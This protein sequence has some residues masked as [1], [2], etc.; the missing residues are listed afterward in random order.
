MPHLKPFFE[1]IGIFLLNLSTRLVYFYIVGVRDGGD[2][3]FYVQN[4]RTVLENFGNPFAL[5]DQ[6]IYPYYWLYPFFLIAFQIQA[7]A[8]IITQVILQSL[9]AVL[10]YQIGKKLWSAPVGLIAGVAYA[11]F[12][13]VFQWDLYMLTDSLY[14]SMMI[15]SVYLVMGAV[16]R[17]TAAAWLA[18]TFSMVGLFLLRPTSV[19]YLASVGFLGAMPMP[20]KFRLYVALVALTAIV[21]GGGY[22]TAYGSQKAFGVAYSV[23]YYKDLLR[24]GVVVRDRPEYSLSLTWDSSFTI[25]NFF[26]VISLFEHR[27]VAFWRFYIPAYS[28]DHRLL[29]LL[30]FIPLYG[31]AFV[32]GLSI[33][34]RKPI[35]QRKSF[36]VV[37]ILAYWIFQTLTEVDFDWRYR[38]PVLPWVLLFAAYGVI[39][40]KRHYWPAFKPAL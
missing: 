11:F 16:E 30:T 39:V 22:L 21:L 34:T 29:N 40:A 6:G 8:V 25:K 33:F 35:D 38:I 18:P 31:F 32:G 19:V 1:P 9:A 27:A 36:L 23:Y 24:Q 17:K 26:R 10:L 14:L 7:S 5:L 15:A 20:A 4:A 12:F 3:W 13:E 2:T 37:I 28:P